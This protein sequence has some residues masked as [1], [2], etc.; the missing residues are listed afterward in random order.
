MT[1]DECRL[2]HSFFLIKQNETVLF[3]CN[4]RKAPVRRWQELR[5]GN[6]MAIIRISTL[7][8]VKHATLLIA[9]QGDVLLSVDPD[10]GW[11]PASR[12]WWGRVLT[13]KALIFPQT[14]FLRLETEDSV[15]DPMDL[16]KQAPAGR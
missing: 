9:V 8:A 15:F 1:Y 7:P 5:T 16:R 11:Y 13:G 2:R 4:P 3:W 14:R 10:Y 12:D 6:H